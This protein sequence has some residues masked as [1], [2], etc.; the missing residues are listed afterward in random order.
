MLSSQSV[1]FYFLCFGSIIYWE[2][3]FEFK[4]RGQIIFFPNGYSVTQ[5]NSLHFSPAWVW[6]KY[7]VFMGLLTDPVFSLIWLFVCPC[8]ILHYCSYYNLLS[9]SIVVYHCISAEQ[10]GCSFHLKW[11]CQI[12]VYT[13]A[14]CQEYPWIHVF[15]LN[16]YIHLGS[17]KTS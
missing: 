17:Q 5:Y 12:S 3:M 2:F 6:V 14:A 10:A 1:L 16:I 11:N 4:C 9:D 7:S 8:S 13:K 15:P